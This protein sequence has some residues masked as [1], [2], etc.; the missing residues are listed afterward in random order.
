MKK[1]KKIQILIEHP[2]LSSKKLFLELVSK[3]RLQKRL[4]N[5]VTEK[6]VIVQSNK[7]I[8]SMAKTA[9]LNNNKDNDKVRQPYEV[10]VPTITT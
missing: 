8:S 1:N 4:Q 2:M 5:S 6:R 3:F 9:K 10:R 7:T